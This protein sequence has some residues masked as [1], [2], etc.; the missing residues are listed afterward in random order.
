MYN[1]FD[2]RIVFEEKKRKKICSCMFSFINF[3]TK[4]VIGWRVIGVGGGRDLDFG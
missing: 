4:Y 2:S 1:S 3:F